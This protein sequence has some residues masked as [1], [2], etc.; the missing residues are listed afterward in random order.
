MPRTR[1]RAAP[2][3]ELTPKDRAWIARY[4]VHFNASRASREIGAEGNPRRH[5]YRMQ[6]RPRVE[7]E[8]QRQLAADNQRYLGARHAVIRHLLAVIL[9]DPSRL[10]TRDGNLRPWSR[11]DEEDRMAVATL[12]R[13]AYRQA[14]GTEGQKVSVKMKNS[15]QA[16]ATLAKMLGWDRTA[17]Q[18]LGADPM[19]EAAAAF[20]DGMRALL[21]RK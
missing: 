13:A 2:E 5:A 16:A 4:M 17:E 12:S 10:M 1:L 19:A 3:D 14:D 9:A 7:E 21:E 20:A 11:I 6:S 8:I 18:D 15:I